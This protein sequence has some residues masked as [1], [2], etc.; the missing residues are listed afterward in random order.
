MTAGYTTTD[1]FGTDGDDTPHSKIPNYDLPV[2][3]QGN[4][5]FPAT[6][7]PTSV[8]LVFLDYVESDVLTALSGLGLNYTKSA[9]TQYL[10]K[11]FTTN[12]YLPLYAQQFWSKGPVCAVGQGVQ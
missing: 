5:S 12:S 2:Y 10:P 4:A 11:S 7:E 8:D 3:V 9:V 1:D 6:G